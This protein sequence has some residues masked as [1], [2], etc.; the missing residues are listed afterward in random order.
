MKQKLSEKT[1]KVVDKVDEVMDIT[2]IDG[3]NAFRNDS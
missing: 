1:T 2:T 3:G